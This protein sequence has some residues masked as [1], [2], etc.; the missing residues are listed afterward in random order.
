MTTKVKVK[1]SS[2]DWRKA[3]AKKR[4]DKWRKNLAIGKRESDLHPSIMSIARKQKGLRQEDVA[5]ELDIAESTFQTIER[6]KLP[7]EED[8][9][10]KI[11]KILGM[12]IPQLFKKQ[13]S[14]FVAVVKTQTLN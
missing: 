8:R 3:A 4:G 11:A 13:D 10:Q 1:K 14:K 7:V 9:A 2:T 5:R 12:R 6:G